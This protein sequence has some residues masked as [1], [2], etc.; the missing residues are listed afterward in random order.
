MDHEAESVE[1]KPESKLIEKHSDLSKDTNSTFNLDKE[2]K[3]NL[4]LNGVSLGI[5]RVQFDLT[6]PHVKKLLQGVI[7]VFVSFDFLDLPAET[8]ETES[9]A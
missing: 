6:L 8:L 7:Q 5:K 1:F 9:C 2:T 3:T 4:N